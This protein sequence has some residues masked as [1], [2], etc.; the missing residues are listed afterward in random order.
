MRDYRNK[1]QEAREQAEKAPNP[2]IATHY[3]TIAAHWEM[4]AN[5][6]LSILEWKRTRGV[7]A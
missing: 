1:A 5:E 4:L 7:S 6:R 3:R 2:D